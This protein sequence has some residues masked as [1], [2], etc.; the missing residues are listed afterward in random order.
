MNIAKDII[1]HFIGK[2]PR[3]E[4]RYYYVTFQSTRGRPKMPVAIEYVQMLHGYNFSST[5]VAKLLGVSRTTLWQ[6][7]SKHG[8]FGRSYDPLT[9]GE[10]GTIVRDTKRS[11][12]YDGEV[13]MLGH[14]RAKGIH[15]QR[16]RFRDSIHRVDPINVACDGAPGFQDGNTQVKGPHALWHID[17]NLKLANFF[18]YISMWI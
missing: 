7:M 3:E 9:D 10:L 1:R 14:L 17:M 18:F 4:R 6:R 2:I 12:P 5:D 13:V 8:L 15:V 11:F 16:W